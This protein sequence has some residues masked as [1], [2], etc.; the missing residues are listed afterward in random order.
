MTGWESEAHLQNIPSG[1]YEFG[2]YRTEDEAESIA[3]SADVLLPPIQVNRTGGRKRDRGE[4]CR[5]AGM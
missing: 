1:S 5:E 4:V 3:A 2:P